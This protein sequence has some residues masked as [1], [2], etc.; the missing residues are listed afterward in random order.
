MKKPME[1]K[2]PGKE[3][4]SYFLNYTRAVGGTPDL[5]KFTYGSHKQKG[6]FT[7]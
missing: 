6:I 2:K 4:N 3:R 7:R 5:K 1:T